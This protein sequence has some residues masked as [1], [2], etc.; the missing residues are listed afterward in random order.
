MKYRT[1]SRNKLI[2]DHLIYAVLLIIFFLGFY[3]KPIF[4]NH[5][6]D[7]D[8]NTLNRET[9]KL[10][11]EQLDPEVSWISNTLSGIPVFRNIGIEAKLT[12]IIKKILPENFPFMIFYL[13]LGGF[14]VYTI[15]V[16][17]SFH[18]VIALISASFFSLSFYFIGF[19]LLRRADILKFTGLLPWIIF[20]I[21]YL[22][23]RRSLLASGL[24]SLSLILAIKDPVPGL[25]ASILILT[26]LFWIINLIQSLVSRKFKSF[27]VFS[28]L[29][30]ISY[31]IAF[32]AI[33]YPGFFLIKLQN[34]ISG[35]LT[36]IPLVSI[37]MIYCNLLFI[38]FWG[39]LVQFGTDNINDEDSGFYYYLRSVITGLVI[40]LILLVIMRLYFDL[41]FITGLILI[42]LTGLIITGLLILLYKNNKINRT[43][44]S[45]LLI[46]VSLVSL[47]ICGSRDLG[48]LKSKAELPKL[49]ERSIS[50]TFFEDD[51]EIFRIYPLGTEFK[52]NSWGTY[53]QTI[54]GHYNYRLFRYN[55][56]LERC[57]NT[58]LQNRVPINWNII[59]ML[60][61]K[62]LIYKDKISV[63]NLEYSFYDLDKKNIIYKNIRYL[64]RVWFVDEIEFLGSESEILKRLNSGDFDPSSTA[65]I[66]SELPGI[67]RSLNSGI[68]IDSISSGL[69]KITT[70]TD[71]TL[72]LVIS[73]IYFPGNWKA[74]LNGSEIPVHAVNYTLCGV[75]IPAG[76]HKLIFRFELDELPILM[77]LNLFAVI[78]T[79][80]MIFFGI[81]H[82]VRK[83]YK[84]E[85]VYVIKR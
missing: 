53:N 64:P 41:L 70:K 1:I 55:K 72:F 83:N 47:F 35:N 54:G 16:F 65:I 56:V 25:I 59:N 15:F 44:F 33:A 10:Q 63:N 39:V 73:E 11:L 6:P 32:L 62:Y 38:F 46:I 19:F 28:I 45:L 7:L 71:T 27:L 34:H 68:K 76:E 61:V 48:L 26:L 66:E 84:G 58:E 13:L 20:L 12:S 43:L 40:L 77:K 57:L 30:L 21:L 49:P 18:R 5:Q 74:Y 69:L 81:Y 4:L 42:I 31:I 67:G 79:F 80:I 17:Y 52:N 37:L 29:L 78:I 23:N 60:N 36:G 50:D 85:I 9:F 82:Y 14:G 22:K 2:S 51:K 24:L 3:F 75:V 8:H